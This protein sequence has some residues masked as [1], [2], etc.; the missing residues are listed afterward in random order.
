MSLKETK[1]H[2]SK[3]TGLYI[4]LQVLFM[5]L[6]SVTITNVAYLPT[7]CRATV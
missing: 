2:P 3:G 6:Y 1:G 4:K 7:C 5:I